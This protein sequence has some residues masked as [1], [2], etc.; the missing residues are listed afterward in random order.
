M[1]FYGTAV[2]C[3]DDAAIRDIVPPGVLPDHQLRLLN[4]DAQVR[5]VNVRAVEWTDA[6]HGPASQRCH[7][8]DLPM[9]C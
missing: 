8:P 1:P 4:E 9:W 2:L 6:L 7:L 3:T 5:A